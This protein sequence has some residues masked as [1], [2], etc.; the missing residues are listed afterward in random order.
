MRW[1]GLRG[2]GGGRASWIQIVLCGA[3]LGCSAAGQYVRTTG[4]CTE[5]R[6]ACETRCERLGDQ[7]DCLA[8]C[9]LDAKLCMK[10]QGNT[11]PL[12]GASPA[13]ISEDKALLVDLVGQ[14]PQHSPELKVELGGPVQVIDAAHQFDPGGRIAVTF[15][16][17]EDIRE[18]EIALAHAPV[19]DG[20][21]CFVTITLGDKTL[22]GRYA[23]PRGKD[24]R[25]TV[26]TWNLT[27][28]I[29]A[30]DPEARAK[31]LTLFVYNNDAA[32]SSAPYRL[33][34]IQFFYRTLKMEAPTGEAP[35]NRALSAP[36]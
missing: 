29:N 32:G 5:Q 22:A 6:D 23:P 21:N 30:L 9:L 28:Q 11:A 35:D 26:E 24:G 1:A 19:G 34:S 36:R 20:T 33:G 14:R 10:A 15:T 25:L 13:R 8:S 3:A 7:R 12:V 18:A 2:A 16:L 31:P 4:A 27:P 17:P